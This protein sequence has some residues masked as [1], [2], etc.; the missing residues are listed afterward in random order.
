MGIKVDF[1]EIKELA[2]RFKSH[3][4]KEKLKEIQKIIVD[5]TNARHLAR[6][7]VTTPVDTGT[8]RREWRTI[9]ATFSG[10]KCEAILYNN[11]NYVIYLEYGH[12]TRSGRG[13]VK[14]RF[15][16]SK[17]MGKVKAD[18]KKISERELKRILGGALNGK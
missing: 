8:A 6:T 11:V 16:M 10:R 14:G 13:W 2:K 18:L 1:S 9:P 3:I 12:R 5:E 7:V 17:S 4:G 15:M